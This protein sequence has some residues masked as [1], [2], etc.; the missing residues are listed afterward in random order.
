MPERVLIIDD[1]LTVNVVVAK[2][3]AKA[4]FETRTAFTAEEA[5]ARAG[6][7]RFDLIITDLRLPK[8][9]GI[10][11]LRQ[12][13]GMGVTDRTPVIVLSGHID[14]AAQKTAQALGATD[15][16]QKPF[17]AGDLVLRAR[18]AIERGPRAAL[19]QRFAKLPA[20]PPAASAPPPPAAA[21]PPAPPPPPPPA[22]AAAR[23]PAGREPPPGSRLARAL[24]PPSAERPDCVGTLEHIRVAE[25]VRF[26]F[27]SRRSGLIE[28][29]RGDE[30]GEIVVRDGEVQQAAIVA[31]GEEV[32]ARSWPSG[33]CSPGRAA[34]SAS[35]SARSRP[36]RPSRPRPESSSARRS[37]AGITGRSGPGSEGAHSHSIVPGGFEVMSNATRLI[38][39]TSFTIRDDIAASTS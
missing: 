29:T 32:G 24:A 10:E 17:D 23:P 39:F 8:T 27:F 9:D 38:P 22:P 15:F 20:A 5:V 7:E 12:L 2:M 33:G 26:L 13:G 25:L 28:I 4:G 11:L 14:A 6:Q 3:L 1:D 19:S 16:I 21:R 18:R 31:G 35:R 30:R 34:A 37:A 36:A